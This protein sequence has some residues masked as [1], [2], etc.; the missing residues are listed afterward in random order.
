[1]SVSG[2]EQREP[3]GWNHRVLHPSPCGGRAG[4]GFVGQARCD[5]LS[6]PDDKRNARLTV[7]EIVLDVFKG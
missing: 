3:G 1:M 4:F 6:P 7:S 5:S 2:E